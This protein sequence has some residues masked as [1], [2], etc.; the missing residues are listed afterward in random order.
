MQMCIKF[1]VIQ[2]STGPIN[3][4]YMEYA[5]MSLGKIKISDNKFQRY[6]T[7]SDATHDGTGVDFFQMF[8]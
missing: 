7:F 4:G 5:G 6:T 2:Q 3:Y 1:S 8:N